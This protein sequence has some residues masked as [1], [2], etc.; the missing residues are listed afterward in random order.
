MDWSMQEKIFLQPEQQN[1]NSIA[2]K[3]KPFTHPSR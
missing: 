1:K 3:N 2:M